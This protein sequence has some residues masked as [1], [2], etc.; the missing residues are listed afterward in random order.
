M[1]HKNWLTKVGK[2][3][4]GKKTGENIGVGQKRWADFLLTEW[5]GAKPGP[6]GVGYPVPFITIARD[7]SALL[8]SIPQWDRFY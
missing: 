5:L 3:K 1:G 6:R 7:G 2:I 8:V 4:V